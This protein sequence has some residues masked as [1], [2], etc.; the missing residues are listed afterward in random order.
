MDPLKLIAFFQQCQAANKG[1]DFLEKF[2]KDKKAG[3]RK[4]DGSS[5]HCA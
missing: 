5:S 2:P 4:E 3:K 1:V